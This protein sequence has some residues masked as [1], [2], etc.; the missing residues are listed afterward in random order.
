MALNTLNTLKFPLLWARP[1]VIF[2][3]CREENV[4]AFDVYDFELR[5]L[6]LE[7]FQRHGLALDPT[8]RHPA[9][10]AGQ[11]LAPRICGQ[12]R[13]GEGWMEIDGR[14]G[15]VGCDFLGDF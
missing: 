15:W 7:V 14:W 4:F 2:I 5:R 8:A 1:A 12:L 11:L 3:P 13:R 6:V 9:R 10:P